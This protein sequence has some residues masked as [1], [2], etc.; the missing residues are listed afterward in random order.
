MNAALRVTDGTF[1]LWQRLA[2]FPPGDVD[3]AL[4]HLQQWII[5]AVGADNAIWI[6]AVR[7]LHG[8]STKKDPFFGWRLRARQAFNPDPDAYQRQYALLRHRS[9]R[10]VDAGVLPAPACRKA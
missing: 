2:E 4:R 6:G 3:S 8:T 10:A 7:V 1:E 9:L 5:E